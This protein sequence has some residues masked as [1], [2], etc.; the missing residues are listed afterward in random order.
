M[1]IDYYIGEDQVRLTSAFWYN[2][3]LNWVA[4]MGDYP[5]ILDH[6]PIHGNYEL[7]N[8]KASM[9][10]GSISKLLAEVNTLLAGNCP[11][12]AR[13][14]LTEMK[15]GCELALANKKRITMDDGA[16]GT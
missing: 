11:E 2:E 14:I 15:R 3:F 7:T 9:Y 16:W 5:Q 6:S 8:E 10:S 4:S 12:F 1:G 13:D